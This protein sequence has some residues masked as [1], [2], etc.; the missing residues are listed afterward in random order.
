[1]IKKFENFNF[2][3]IEKILN[4]SKLLLKI[5]SL[6][7]FDS[8]CFVSVIVIKKHTFIFET[9]FFIL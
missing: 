5:L 9:V 7:V 1:M 4:I 8:K 6:V 3:R 2:I